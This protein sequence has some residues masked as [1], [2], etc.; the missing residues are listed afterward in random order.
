MKKKLQLKR[1]EDYYI[2]VLLKEVKLSEVMSSPVISIDVEEN[3]TEVPENFKKYH[4]RH[5]PI[6]GGDNKL[7]GLISQKDVQVAGVDAIG[8]GQMYRQ[9]MF[10]F[11]EQEEDTISLLKLQRNIPTKKPF[12]LL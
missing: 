5:L 1:S 6:T 2:K 9:S 8:V 3:F 4:I 10:M 11:S 7:V 12:S